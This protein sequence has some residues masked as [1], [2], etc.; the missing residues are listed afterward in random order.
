MIVKQLLP[1]LVAKALT[2]STKDTIHQKLQSFLQR[3]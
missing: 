1:P 3:L 2:L